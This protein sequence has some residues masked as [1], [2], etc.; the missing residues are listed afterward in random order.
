MDECVKALRGSGAKAVP[1]SSSH[2]TTRR[3]TTNTRATARPHTPPC[4]DNYAIKSTT[5]SGG[6]GD[7]IFMSAPSESCG[8]GEWVCGSGG[9]GG[10]G[11]RVVGKVSG[12]FGVGAG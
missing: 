12:R 6:W 10:A 9:E 7:D 5:A 1:G 3:P 11:C 8:A 4:S 2:P